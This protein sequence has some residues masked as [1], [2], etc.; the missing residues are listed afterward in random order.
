MF[1][2]K[3]L[4]RM[5]TKIC[6]ALANQMF[7]DPL[8]QVIGSTRSKQ[9]LLQLCTTV[10]EHNHLIELGCTLGIQVQFYSCSIL[11]GYLK[12]CSNALYTFHSSSCSIYV[13]HP[14]GY[15]C[16]WVIE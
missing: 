15:Y 11:S 12:V 3:C 7:L 8:G 1:V 5:P 4:L 9:I 6:V 2:L 14:W 10:Q 13:F 16:F